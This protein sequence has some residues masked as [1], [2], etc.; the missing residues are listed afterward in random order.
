MKYNKWEPIVSGKF[1]RWVH[2]WNYAEDGMAE[3]RN[4]LFRIIEVNVRDAM[5]ATK[6]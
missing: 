2:L 5:G 4:F 3:M 1:E 6:W